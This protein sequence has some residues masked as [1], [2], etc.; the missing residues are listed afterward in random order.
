MHTLN[1][2]NEFLFKIAEKKKNQVLFFIFGSLS[3]LT[4]IT[5]FLF[6]AQSAVNSAELS[7]QVGSLVEKVLSFFKWL[8]N[9]NAVL[10]ITTYIRKIAHFTLY[11]FLGGFLMATF[12][13]TKIKQLFHDLFFSASIG[14][15]YSITDEFHQLFIAGRSGQISDVL[16]DFCGVVFGIII[17]L[18]IYKIIKFSAK[19]TKA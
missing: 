1:S 9:D 12:V 7:G 15:F 2:K 5:I 6:S 19:K 11:A 13:N 4:M 10:W 3:L 8:L 18:F 14:L 17:S 16:L